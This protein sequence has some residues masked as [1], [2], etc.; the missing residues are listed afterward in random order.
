MGYF[1]F[2]YGGKGKPEGLTGQFEKLSS[3]PCM[4]LKQASCLCELVAWHNN[5]SE[6][7]FLHCVI[8]AMLVFYL[9]AGGLCETGGIVVLILRRA[10]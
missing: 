9:S 3:L 5:N 10:G 2:I 6:H 8:Y 7:L 1:V 4:S